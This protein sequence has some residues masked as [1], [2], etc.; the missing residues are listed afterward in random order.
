MN[1][2]KVYSLGTDALKP[3]FA[4]Q[5]DPDFR[6]FKDLGISSEE[7][8]FRCPA[9]EPPESGVGTYEIPWLGQ[10]MLRPNGKVDQEKTWTLSN[11]RIDSGFKV[12]QAFYNWKNEATNSE[13]GVVGDIVNGGFTSWV[14]IVPLGS[15]GEPKAGI[16]GWGLEDLWVTR[17]SGVSF[18]Q[19][20][21][22]PVTCSLTFA[23]LVSTE[24]IAQNSGL[25]PQ[26]TL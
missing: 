5:F 16:E 13:T 7:M 11:V 12:L 6:F 23:F 24:N 14:K 10:K 15:D 19:E 17:V 1:L 20:G 8:A 25:A 9:A 3:M 21:T 18:E 4:L 2:K 22:G 26:A